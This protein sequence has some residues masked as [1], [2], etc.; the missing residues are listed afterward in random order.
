VQVLEP[1]DQAQDW[2]SFLVN[3]IAARAPYRRR[4]LGKQ[5]IEW[6]LEQAKATGFARLTANVWE[7]NLPARAL[8]EGAGFRIQARIEVPE[9]PELHHI[10]ASLLVVHP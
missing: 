5:L 7:D 1:I 3:G 4:G 10:G 9:H 2:E 8:F 6:A